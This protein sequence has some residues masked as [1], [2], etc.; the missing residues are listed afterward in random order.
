MIRIGH[1]KDNLRLVQSCPQLSLANTTAI[2][3]SNDH[4]KLSFQTSTLG[5]EATL[6]SRI[7]KFIERIK[8]HSQ[9]HEKIHTLVHCNYPFDNFSLV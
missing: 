8:R 9:D 2:D 3:Y 1:F 5:K 6:S 4:V 7:S